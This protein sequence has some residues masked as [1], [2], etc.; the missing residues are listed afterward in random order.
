LEEF[1][2]EKARGRNGEREKKRGGKKLS[3]AGM[4]IHPA[5]REP[6]TSFETCPT[7]REAEASKSHPGFL[8]N[9]GEDC[10]SAREAARKLRSVMAKD[11]IS[12]GNYQSVLREERDWRK[13][14]AEE[15][16]AILFRN[17]EL[18]AMREAAEHLHSNVVIEGSESEGEIQDL[19]VACKDLKSALNRMG[20]L[21][22]GQ[23]KQF[24]SIGLSRLEQEPTTHD[25]IHSHSR[26]SPHPEWVWISKASTVDNEGRLG[27]AAASKDFKRLSAT[28]RKVFIRPPPSEL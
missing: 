21:G 7:R 10:S 12:K 11:F 27:F 6:P 24:E 19:E 18:R 14:Q 17:P 15:I 8:R 4:S 25:V 23:D 5:R 1:S 22:F 16:K 20:N 26:H 13:K 3:G 9:H 2:I 28:A